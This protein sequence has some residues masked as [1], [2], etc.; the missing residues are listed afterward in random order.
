MHNKTKVLLLFLYKLTFI[1]ISVN[2]LYAQTPAFPGAEGFGANTVGGRGG[3][4]IKVTNVNDSGPG[5]LRA[6]L[7]EEGPRII[8]F[9]TGGIINLETKL[10]IKNPFV[11][12]AGQTAPGDGICIRG[13]GIRIYT[14]D[15]IIR[16]LRVRPGDIDFGPPNNWGG[17]DAIT[18]A[19]NPGSK[20]IPYNI[21]IDRCSLSWGVDEIIGMWFDTHDVTVQNCIISE[22]LHKSKHTKGAHGMGMLIGY[23]A[24]NISIHHNL[25]SSNNQRNPMINGESLVD[26]RNNVIYNFE[27]AASHIYVDKYTPMELIRL[28]YVNNFIRKGPNS[29]NNH[30]LVIN[31]LAKD[32]SKI[33]ISG[34]RSLFV[35]STDSDNWK[36][37]ALEQ[38]NGHKIPL[39]D[40]HRAIREFPHP[41]VTTL[42]AE[43]AYAYILENAGA[44]LPHRD[45]ID[46]KVIND[47]KN[48]EGA[49]VNSRDHVLSWPSYNEGISVKDSDDD[50]MP[51]HWEKKYDLDSNDAT[52]QNSDH[53]N[54]GYTN[55]EE[56][57]N[58]TPPNNQLSTPLNTHSYFAEQNE[59][60][61]LQFQLKQ[62][63]PNPFVDNTNLSFIID[64]YSHVALK[65][66]DFEGKEIETFIDDYL[67]E[68]EYEVVVELSNQNP[69]IYNFILISDGQKEG[70]K[71]IL[72]K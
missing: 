27:R 34:N 43:G 22:A 69:G 18:I 56:Y 15:I 23:K 24:T 37:V 13:E 71:A 10:I 70:V 19:N 33:F 64:K 16:Y 67:Y 66:V 58:N 54:D 35:E 55:I 46:K 62:N 40:S 11:T 26:F 9:T 4:V 3:K 31:E 38:I 52:D 6:A 61:S 30:G 72:K 8:V 1:I 48:G 44:T 21:I 14:H 41:S 36:M 39:S 20:N 53:D 32:R 59:V 17:L 57:I 60:N 45:P 12:I 7:A 5:S 49:I 28:N 63:F 29:R 2:T 25:F 51:D 47:L 42:S 68:G 65:L 50:G